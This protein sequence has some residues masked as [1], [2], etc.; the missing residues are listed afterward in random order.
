MSSSG[1]TYTQAQCNNLKLCFYDGEEIFD[2]VLISAG[3][4]KVINGID[5]TMRVTEF[6][7][8]R[9]TLATLYPDEWVTVVCSRDESP[10]LSD[11]SPARSSEVWIGRVP[12]KAPRMAPSSTASGGW[13]RFL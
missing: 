12:K 7:A 13:C 9:T 6:S 5:K 4:Y 2:V 10:Q 1:D 3:T 8:P 11:S